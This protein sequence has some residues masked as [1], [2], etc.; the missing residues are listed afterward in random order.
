MIFRELDYDLI[1]RLCLLFKDHHAEMGWAGSYNAQKVRDHAR[2]YCAGRLPGNYFL[3][4][5]DGEVPLGYIL[6]YHN[7]KWWNDEIEIGLELIYV[8]P[9]AR[10][11]GVARKMIKKIEQWSSDVYSARKIVFYGTSDRFSAYLSRLGYEK[12]GNV[13]EKQL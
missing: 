7:N 2:Y 3:V 8:A 5:L 4:A 9:Y 6:A 1:G 12:T 10:S 11:R 13:V